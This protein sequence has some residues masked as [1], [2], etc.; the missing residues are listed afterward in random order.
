MA[1]ITLEQEE[2]TFASTT[3]VSR[4]QANVVALP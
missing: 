2:H 1:H 3:S 4:G